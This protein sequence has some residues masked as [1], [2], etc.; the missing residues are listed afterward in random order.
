MM[1]LQNICI[2]SRAVWL[3]VVIACAAYT[4]I[5][6]VL[7][8]WCCPARIFADGEPLEVQ[9]N[10]LTSR[11]TKIPFE[12]YDFKFCPP[13]EVRNERE[14]LG[15]VLAGDRIE[16][17]PYAVSMGTNR[18]CVVCKVDMEEGVKN[19]KGLVDNEYMVNMI[20]DN[21]PAATPIAVA[22]TGDEEGIQPYYSMGWPVGG[23]YCTKGDSSRAPPTTA[24][25]FVYNHSFRM[26]YHTPDP[27]QE[28][29]VDVD[30]TIVSTTEP[31]K[32][33]TPIPGRGWCGLKSS[34][35][36]FVTSTTEIRTS[37]TL[38]MS[39]HAQ[40]VLFSTSLEMDTS[41]V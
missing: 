32:L 10:S 39:Q 1:G 12:Y 5:A 13:E 35:L 28:S 24:A 7:S 34:R 21:L 20:A 25:Y 2:A 19:M 36:V 29:V 14:N 37:L 27:A 15:M 31:K 9:V 18:K 17:T 8:A 23:K 4:Q 22:A 16:S 11:K 3:F 38:Q 40:Q 26:Y 6:G 33:I 30:G 41:K